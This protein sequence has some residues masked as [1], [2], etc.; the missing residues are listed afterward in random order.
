MRL[1]KLRHFFSNLHS[2]RQKVAADMSLL[3]AREIHAVQQYVQTHHTKLIVSNRDVQQQLIGERISALSGNGY[4]FSE[5]R[6]FQAGDE[7]RSINWRIYAR[8]GELHRKVF[9]EEKRQQ[10]WLVVDRRH[11]MRFGTRKRLKVTTAVRHALA[12]LYQ[13]QMQ[14]IEVG[15]VILNE[16][17]RWIEAKAAT[18]A[19][20]Y[21][22]EEMNLSC[23]PLDNKQS[24][25]GFTPIIRS[26][27]ERLAK[28]AMIVLIS[29]FHDLRE[30][31]IAYIY[32]LTQSHTIKAV[33][34]LDVIENSLPQHG[35]FDLY[36]PGNSSHAHVNCENA[37]HKEAIESRFHQRE[38][39]ISA[40]LTEA[41]AEYERILTTDEPFSMEAQS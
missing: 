39:M 38:K 28:G 6:P 22:V 1:H 31:D 35:H 19:Q 5:N 7:S 33:H 16:V 15:G 21:L 14:Q 25:T 20:Q 2:R 18:A 41:G 10:L 40:W 23:P 29:D 3:T 12:Y 32:Q 17:P 13:A 11:T 27:H 34:V 36:W 30:D 26:L 37:K 24:C 4:E 8:T 9:Y